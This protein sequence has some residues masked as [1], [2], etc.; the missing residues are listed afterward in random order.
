MNRFD[1]RWLVLVVVVLMFFGLINVSLTPIFSVVV[2]GLC[3]LWM[4]EAGR[5]PW[6]GRRSAF[7]GRVTYWRGQPVQMRPPARRGFSLPPMV[8]LVGSVLYFA[9]CALLV[10]AVVQHILFLLH[11]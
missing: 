5:R 6:M 8:P 11:G 7:G 1:W 10:F 3:A 2:L 4:F 9:V